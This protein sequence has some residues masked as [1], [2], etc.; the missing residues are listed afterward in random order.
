MADPNPTPSFGPYYS[1]GAALTHISMFLNIALPGKDSSSW[2]I[3]WN[4]Y[5]KACVLRPPTLDKDGDGLAI[6]YEWKGPIPPD[7]AAPRPGTGGGQSMES[8]LG[9]F[10]SEPLQSAKSLA[11]E[12]VANPAIRTG[13][14]AH[15]LIV[16]NPI[17]TDAA[18]LGLDVWGV[19]AS[20]AAVCGF[21]AETAATGVTGVGAPAAAAGAIATAGSYSAFLSSGALMVADGRHLY[22]EVFSTDDAV[23]AWEDTP[24]YDKA[25]KFGPLVALFDPLREGVQALKSAR[26]LKLLKPVSSAAAKDLATANADAARAA[27]QSA[28]DTELLDKVQAYLAKPGHVSEPIDQKVA[29]ALQDKQAASKAAAAAAKIRAA[30]AQKNFLRL[31]KKADELQKEISDYIAL[32]VHFKDATLVRDAT[33]NAWSGGMY[34]ANNPFSTSYGQTTPGAAAPSI[35][36]NA[37]RALIPT[38]FYKQAMGG[39]SHYFNIVVAAVGAHA[40]GQ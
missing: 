23:K 6:V 39:F 9:K 17:A 5:G 13:I 37:L 34:V 21:G 30:Q 20:G 24:Y 27:S 22:L 35:F 8:A 7:P 32:R 26:D 28:K 36:D 18:S 12:Y 33:T 15:N 1:G 11:I 29:A 19:L 4:E 10:F 38:G 2:G 25:E 16:A 14:F 31:S 40:T 3:V